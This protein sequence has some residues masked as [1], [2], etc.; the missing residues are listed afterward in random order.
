MPCMLQFALSNDEDGYNLLYLK[1]SMPCMLLFALSNDQDG[2]YL[3]PQDQDA[4]YVSI[5]SV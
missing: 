1:I 2:H 4:L 3:L 5:C